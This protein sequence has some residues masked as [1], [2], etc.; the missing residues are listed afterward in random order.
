MNTIENLGRSYLDIARVAQLT[1]AG[2]LKFV[3]DHP[4]DKVIGVHIEHGQ[5]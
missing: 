5:T 1:L 3:P 2:R 4:F